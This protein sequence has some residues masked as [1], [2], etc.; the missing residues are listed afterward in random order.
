MVPNPIN[1]YGFVAMDGT[2]PYKFIGFGAMD[3]TKPYIHRVWWP[4]FFFVGVVRLLFHGTATE[5]ES[6]ML[7]LGRLESVGEPRWE[8]W[9]GNKSGGEVALYTRNVKHVLELPTKV[10]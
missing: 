4:Q 8:R 9:G 6:Q 2:K 10:L 3:V 1:S 5:E 7:A